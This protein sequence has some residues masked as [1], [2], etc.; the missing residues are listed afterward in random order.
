VGNPTVVCYGGASS[1]SLATTYT[2]GGISYQWS[3]AT[4]S[5]G[6][7]T[8]IS[9]A[10]VASYTDPSIIAAT[11]YQAVAT[12]SSS[13]LS[14]TATP[15]QVI[16]Q[17]SPVYA[18]VPFLE[19]FDNVWQ[20]RCD[21]RNVPVTANWDDFPTTGNN[22]WRRQNDGISAGWTNPTFGTV[23]PIG[24]GCA[25]FHSSSA[26]A[27]T[28]GDLDL[29]VNMGGTGNY[30]LSFYNYNSSGSDSLL[31]F[32]SNNAGFSFS[33]IGS[34][35]LATSWTKQ[36]I[37]LGSVASPSC[38][39]RFRGVSDLGFSDVGID[40]VSVFTATCSVTPSVGSIV[41]PNNVNIGTTNSYSLT[42]SA[43]N[44]QWY[45]ASSASGPWS[46]IA[47]ATTTPVSLLASPGGTVYYS[48]VASGVGCTSFTSSVYAVTVAP[49][50]GDMP[51]GP[52]ANTNFSSTT[53]YYLDNYTSQPNE[54]MPTGGSC[55]TNTTWCIA[56]VENSHWFTFVAPP[57]G[58]VSVQSP[59]FDTQLAVWNATNC[60]DLTTSGSTATLIAAN[61]DDPNYISHG[62]VVYSS[63]LTATC[64]TPGATY[65]LQLD[66]YSAASPSDSTRIVITDLGYNSFTGLSPAYCLPNNTTATLS[67]NFPGGYFT[68]DASTNTITAFSPSVAGVGSH[69]IMYTV[70]GCTS[71]SVVAV[72][73]QPTVTASAGSGTVCAGG[74]TPLSANGASTY[75][76]STGATG[77][78][79]A[80]TPTTTTTFSV[81]GNN[82]SGCIGTGTVNVVVNALPGVSLTAAQTTVCV[83]GSTVALTGSPAG[84]AYTGSNVTTGV[85]T[86]GAT[87]GTFVPGYAITSSVTGCSNSASVTIIVTACTGVNTIAGKQNA[88]LVYPN[89]NTGVFVVEFNNG[90]P[91]TIEVC[92][93]T[94]RTVLSEK[95]L[96]DKIQLDITALSNGIYFVKVYSSEATEVIKIIKE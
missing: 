30:V 60:A 94:G 16:L 79:I 24:T 88:I 92:D 91:K 27:M 45:Q 57:S 35:N 73:N 59:G 8:A 55:S 89:P 90:Y 33:Q 53:Y 84:G 47:G 26:T 52:T 17:T 51:C 39:V 46:P 18:P 68:L 4:S 87:A 3:T 56:S 62:G 44:I 81:S 7:Y 65:Y 5:V 10:T 14:A 21:I 29:F 1:L 69:T 13:G 49:L 23:T 85:F 48:V 37:T 22:S 74:S 20:N 34:Y 66:S 67:P 61:D 63:Y 6:P 95:T 19:S 72:S 96:L 15:V 86:P 32:F 43:G 58:N 82:G 78:V 28:T 76:W 40:S 25:D 64:L 77:N 41:G 2:L 36:T 54:V 80:V 50:P 42:S 11:W 70:N 75:T 71:S 12:C 93:L 38:I 31:V 9:G 83:N